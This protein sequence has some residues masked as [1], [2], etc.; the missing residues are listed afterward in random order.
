VVSEDV[1]DEAVIY[2]LDTDEAHLLSPNVAR[3]WRAADGYRTVAQ[4]RE[5]VIADDVEQAT[6]VVWGALE[7]LQSKR[8]LDGTVLLPAGA[9]GI[10]RRTMLKRIGLAAVAIPVITS[11]V[12]PT[13]AAAA[14]PSGRGG[15]T[16]GC[17]SAGTCTTG[18]CTS[19][20][21]TNGRGTICC[22]SNGTPQAGCTGTN[23]LA[24][25]NCCSGSCGSGVNAP[26]C[27]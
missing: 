4:L 19:N 20:P 7:Q 9:T 26:K 27:G 15:L 3:I 5:V 25:P 17:C 2:D 11:I 8:L 14:C 10:S 13:P 23:N 6:F 16:Q 12:A 21:N 22:V 18:T 1:G 24:N